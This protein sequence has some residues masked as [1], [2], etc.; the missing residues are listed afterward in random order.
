MG[1]DHHC[2]SLKRKEKAHKRLILCPKGITEQHT[3][4]TGIQVS[5]SYVRRMVSLQ[6]ANIRLRVQMESRQLQLWWIFHWV[7][8]GFTV[9]DIFPKQ[10]LQYLPKYIR[11]D[12]VDLCA[13]L[14]PPEMARLH[15]QSLAA[16]LQLSW[17]PCCRWGWHS[18]CHNSTAM[19]KTL[20]RVWCWC[21]FIFSTLDVHRQECSLPVQAVLCTVQGL[22]LLVLPQLVWINTRG[23]RGNCDC[24]GNEGSWKHF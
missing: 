4:D 10:L 23:I 2:C 3:T 13:H 12:Q 18:A 14:K 17:V 6:L 15:C 5:W 20:C 16:C 21:H 8:L 19:I 22:V 1:S 24:A 11:E 9:L 7:N